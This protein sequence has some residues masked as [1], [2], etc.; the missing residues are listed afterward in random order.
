LATTKVI[1]R[2]FDRFGVILS[3][4]D[5]RLN[6]NYDETMHAAN[7]SRG[8][9][10]VALD[11][12]MFRKKHKKPHLF[13]LGAVFSPLGH[14]PPP[15]IVVPMF[16]G[17]E[18]LFMGQN[19]FVRESRSWWRTRPIFAAFAEHFCGWL[20]GCRVRIGIALS[21]EAVLIVDNAQLHADPGAPRVFRANDAPIITLP[22]HCT[23]LP[24]PAD[25]VRVKPFKDRPSQLLCVPRRIRTRIGSS[26]KL[27]CG[28]V[29]PHL[30]R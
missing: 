10:I 17:A 13:T 3:S 30:Q 20:T 16:S 29:T 23:H 9:V 26:A 15:L 6:F 12:S 18:E 19:A 27:N 8:K 24:R 28:A 2:W 4:V 21:A 5:R 14:G 7:L 25:V 1:G 22:P 11:Q